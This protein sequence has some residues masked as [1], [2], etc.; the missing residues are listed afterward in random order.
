MF[1]EAIQS[2]GQTMHSI[3]GGKQ[4]RRCFEWASQLL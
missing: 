4:C 3:V 2:W 1:G